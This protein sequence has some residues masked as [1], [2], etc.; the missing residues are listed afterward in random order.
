MSGIWSSAISAG[1][2]TRGTA[3]KSAFGD[4]PSCS[5]ARVCPR[6]TFESS[7]KSRLTWLTRRDREGT[8]AV[9]TVNSSS[10]RPNASARTRKAKGPLLQAS[11]PFPPRPC[12]AD[13]PRITHIACVATN[14]SDKIALS[15]RGPLAA[16]KQ[17]RMLVHACEPGRL[18]HH[19]TYT[20]NLFSGLR[21]PSGLALAGV[22]CFAYQIVYVWSQSFVFAR[23]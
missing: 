6:T 22:L 3:A 5:I 19:A 4:S 17:R 12:G 8:T 11:R 18:S 23:R 20:E 14:R 2:Y 21:A 7:C 13:H 1:G 10:S 15:T 9:G 16:F